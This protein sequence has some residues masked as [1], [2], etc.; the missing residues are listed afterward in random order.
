[1]EWLWFDY[2][3]PLR[4]YERKDEKK[5]INKLNDINVNGLMSCAKIYS[6][7]GMGFGA[8]HYVSAPLTKSFSK[9]TTLKNLVILLARM[10]INCVRPKPK[11]KPCNTPG[12]HDHK[13]CM[14][15]TK[16]KPCITLGLHEYK[17]CMAQNKSC[18][19]LG[20]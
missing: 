15:Q 9:D 10:S 18:S 16:K 13:L 20:P 4:M 1:M 3:I 7:I 12:P 2:E 8:W 5:I 11:K 6:G 17:L 14:A 19:T